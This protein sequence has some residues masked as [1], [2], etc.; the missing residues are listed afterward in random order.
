[1]K[2]FIIRG[3]QDAGKTTTCGLLYR[4]LLKKA[5]TQDHIFNGAT[6]NKDSLSINGQ[7]GTFNDFT[8]TITIKK[9]SI[10]IISAG[11]VK[12]ELKISIALITAQLKIDILICCTRSQYRKNSTFELI[13]E[14]YRPFHEMIGVKWITRMEKYNLN[15]KMKP[16]KD[17]YSIIF[18]NL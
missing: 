6:V 17:V 7:T 12:S 13:E 8:A 2:I 18:A 16:V 10:T 9:K 15:K 3:K 4:E 1:M 5:D 14:E 11:D